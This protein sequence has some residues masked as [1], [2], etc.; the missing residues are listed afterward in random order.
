MVR[1]GGRTLAVSR[2][3]LLLQ[4]PTGRREKQAQGKAREHGL[5]EPLRSE[6]A[7]EQETTVSLSERPER[8]PTPEAESA[9]T[10]K[11]PEKAEQPNALSTRETGC[12]RARRPRAPWRC[13][14]GRRPT[15]PA[16]RMMRPRGTGLEASEKSWQERRRRVR[17]TVV[18][19]A[20]VASPL[21]AGLDGLTDG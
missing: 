12:G 3:S 1:V 5:G 2:A 4:G 16:R 20:S 6:R 21:H 10:G 19:A 11:A 14:R 18:S 9:L 17:L 13:R 8:R 15:R 7:V